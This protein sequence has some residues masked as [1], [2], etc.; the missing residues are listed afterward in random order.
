MSKRYGLLL[1]RIQQS[2]RPALCFFFLISFWYTIRETNAMVP[3]Q[4]RLTEERSV[5]TQ[6]QPFWESFSL[7][8]WG[9]LQNEKLVVGCSSSPLTCLW[10]RI[11]LL[12]AMS[13]RIW[14]FVE[15]NNIACILACATSCVFLSYHFPLPRLVRIIPTNHL[16]A[17]ESTSVHRTL[18]LNICPSSKKL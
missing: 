18:R 11:S 9:Y 13:F 10:R 2:H 17:G 8:C 3:W 4:L 16:I 15:G 14:T 5:E 12:S 6:L 1:S 7:M